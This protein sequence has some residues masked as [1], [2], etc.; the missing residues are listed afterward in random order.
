[1]NLKKLLPIGKADALFFFSLG[2]AVVLLI[3]AAV[4]VN[5]WLLIAS[6]L[7][8]AYGFF[9]LYSPDRGVRSKENTFFIRI[10]AF[11]VEKCVALWGRVRGAQKEKATEE[12][13]VRVCPKCGAKLRFTHKTG[14]F[15]I[16]CPRCRHRF[17]VE[18]S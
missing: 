17:R 13:S 3:L 8:M 2:L 11:P 14:T 16:T 1:M 5:I 7:P 10:C 4:F 15:S 6:L 12:M 9:R 18:L